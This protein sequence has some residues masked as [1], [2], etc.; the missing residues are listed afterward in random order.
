MPENTLFTL[1][2]HGAF[3]FWGLGCIP[4]V[5]GVPPMYMPPSAC[6]ALARSCKALSP[7]VTPLTRTLQAEQL[8]GVWTMDGGARLYGVDYDELLASAAA[9]G[10]I[11]PVQA[12]RRAADCILRH[13]PGGMH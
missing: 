5:A 8:A 12:S 3:R 13:A 9:N 4:L 11:D 6:E 2:L 7:T 10:T 1:R